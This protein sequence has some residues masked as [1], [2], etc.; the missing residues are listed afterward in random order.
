[1]MQLWITLWL[2]DSIHNAAKSVVCDTVEIYLGNLLYIYRWNE[3]KLPKLGV[4]PEQSP[5]VMVREA[6]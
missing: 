4:G 5:S 6:T 3:Y 1:M 2:H